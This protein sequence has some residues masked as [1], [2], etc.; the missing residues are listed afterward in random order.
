VGAI[1]IEEVGATL[2]G[3]EIFAIGVPSLFH[4]IFSR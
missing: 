3:W 1:G 4:Q 2:E